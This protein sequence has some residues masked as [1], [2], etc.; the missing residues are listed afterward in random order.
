MWR[1]FCGIMVENEKLLNRKK[2]FKN[3]KYIIVVKEEEADGIDEDWEGQVG[4]LLSS[5]QKMNVQNIEFMKQVEGRIIKSMR[6][7]AD[8]IA[9]DIE[10]KVNAKFLT[11]FKKLDNALNDN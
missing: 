10:K 7:N 4:E 8:I 9:Q 1:E 5:I 2:M 11:I 3:C 6:N